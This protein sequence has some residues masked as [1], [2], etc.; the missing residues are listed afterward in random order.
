MP[1]CAKGFAGLTRSDARV[2]GQ[3][4]VVIETLL[5][6]PRRERRATEFREALLK[7]GELRAGVR[8][9]R[10][11]RASRAGIAAL[12]IHIAD[13]KAHRRVRVRAEKLIFPKRR[14]AIQFQRGAKAQ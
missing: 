10:R 14:D 4:V 12:E 9:A 5:R 8:I 13:A 7:A 1:P 6:R 2:G 3:A 11:D